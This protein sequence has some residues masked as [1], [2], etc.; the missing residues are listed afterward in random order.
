[1][2]HT[3]ILSRL[4]SQK[5]STKS[6]KEK[7]SESGMSKWLHENSVS[8]EI[9]TLL[10]LTNK[11][12]STHQPKIPWRNRLSILSPDLYRKVVHFTCEHEMEPQVSDTTP[13]NQSQNCT[14]NFLSF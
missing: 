7:C 8:P 3:E 13:L 6:D 14:L 12:A 11:R 2:P 9:Q 4:Q 5:F 1:M 10:V